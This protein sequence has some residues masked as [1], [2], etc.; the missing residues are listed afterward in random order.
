MQA[1]KLL[2]IIIVVS[3]P[4]PLFAQVKET[5]AEKLSQYLQIQQQRIGFN[6][7]VVIA[8]KEKVLYSKAMGKAS[9]ELDVPITLHSAFRIASV[10]KQFTAYLVTSAILDGKIRPTDSLKLYFPA[11]NEQNWRNIT[12]HQLLTHTSGV[13]H[14]EGITDYWSL[15]SKLPLSR[16]KAL[17]EIFAM[18]LRT[19]PRKKLPLFKSGLFSPGN[20][21]GN[22]L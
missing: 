5:V 8:E 10:T 21:P 2:T 19:E 14:N 17:K 11:L 22:S 3:L 20:H 16:E 15:K 7:V 6:G 9:F 1:L 18:K 12:I 4:I 13:P